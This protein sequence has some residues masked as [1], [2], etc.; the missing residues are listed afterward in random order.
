L[1]GTTSDGVKVINE[2]PV[3]GSMSVD[4][5]SGWYIYVAWI[6]GEKFSGEFKLGNGAN[7]TI[8]LYTSKVVVE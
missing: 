2:Y 6:G 4:V 3:E 5:P 7:R 1:Q 8:T